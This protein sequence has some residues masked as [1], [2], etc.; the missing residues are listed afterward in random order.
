MSIVMCSVTGGDKMLLSAPPPPSPSPNSCNNA[1]QLISL[2]Q[3]DAV[4]RSMKLLDTRLQYL[5]RVTSDNEKLRHDLTHVV[6]VVGQNRLAMD[7]ITA[8]LGSLQDEV[9]SLA[10]SLQPSIQ[11]M[12]NADEHHRHSTRRKRSIN[13][14]Q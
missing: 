9:H 3:L 14:I 1:V 2:P 13:D 6:G 8:V 11:L 5:H 10:T 4:Q 12:R 7:S